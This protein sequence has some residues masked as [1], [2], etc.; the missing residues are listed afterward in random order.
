MS[1]GGCDLR[2]NDPLVLVW[3]HV[4]DW[5]AKRTGEYQTREKATLEAQDGGLQYQYLAGPC[6]RKEMMK[7]GRQKFGCSVEGP[8]D[9]GFESHR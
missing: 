6:R 4:V 1:S 8:F 9:T 7:R 2:S 5:K 3:C